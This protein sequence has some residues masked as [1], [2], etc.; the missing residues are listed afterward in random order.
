MVRRSML[1]RDVVPLVRWSCSPVISKLLLQFSAPEP[2]KMHVHCFGVFWMDGVGDGTQHCCVISLCGRMGL[3][4][5][6]FFECVV[7]GDG[8]L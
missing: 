6:Y 5:S 7:G 3:W 8:F 4:M 2:V 1:L